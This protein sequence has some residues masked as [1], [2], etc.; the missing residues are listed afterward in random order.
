MD[1]LD[2]YLAELG[3]EEKKQ[4]LASVVAGLSP[5]NE[6]TAPGTVFTTGGR[7]PAFETSEDS[8]TPT[9]GYIPSPGIS[10]E[11]ETPLFT[12]GSLVEDPTGMVQFDPRNLMQTMNLSQVDRPRIQP[13]LT[14]VTVGGSVD[15]LPVM[16]T[17][18][19]QAA[20]LG[21]KTVYGKL[22]KAVKQS[23][24]RIGMDQSTL[25]AEQE[26]EAGQAV[27]EQ[28]TAP[29]STETTE[30]LAEQV[31]TSGVMQPTGA[32]S[33]D[34]VRM[35]TRGVDRTNDQYQ[36]RL[37]LS[38][39]LELQALRQ[40]QK[41]EQVKAQPRSLMDLYRGGYERRAAAEAQRRIN[42]A[43]QYFNRSG[44]IQRE[45]V[46]EKDIERK[47]AAAEQRAAGLDAALQ[48][49][50][51][52]RKSQEAIQKDKLVIEGQKVAASLARLNTLTPYQ[53]G[54][55][56]N[57]SR[58]ASA[59]EKKQLKAM[60]GQMRGTWQGL[61]REANDD[62]VDLRRQET[63]ILRQLSSGF[64]RQ[65]TRENLESQLAEIQKEQDAVRDQ[66]DTYQGALA[67]ET[68][69]AT[70]VSAGSSKFDAIGIRQ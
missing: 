63:N 7:A 36:R 38:R 16:F 61:L 20:E 11:G 49:K 25:F 41:A 15:E 48:E 31:A 55:L 68:E 35:R 3:P 33:M 59:A 2:Q 42:M 10:G 14:P 52:R 50:I 44:A 45:L 65:S 39:L 56:A 29:A 17:P 22:P 62:L 6:A 51:A 1:F 37:Q 18:D 34:Q 46:R 47:A 21:G 28:A 53:K 60:A 26:A 43:R 69:Q 12:I 9:L 64:V 66:R 58:R 5:I 30:P 40:L 32:S 23:I 27:V 57:M 54:I 70:G 67:T 24:D 19:V 4:L 8:V 13:D